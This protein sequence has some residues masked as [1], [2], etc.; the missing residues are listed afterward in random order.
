[1]I[2]KVSPV[3]D[4]DT[5]DHGHLGCTIHLFAGAIIDYYP[6]DNDDKAW[7][8]EVPTVIEAICLFSCRRLR[9]G[10]EVTFTYFRTIITEEWEIDEPDFLDLNF[11]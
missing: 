4:G 7:L 11:N 6:D 3:H 9:D 1:M 10:T 5:I 2:L 8:V